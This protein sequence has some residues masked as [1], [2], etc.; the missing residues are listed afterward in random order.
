MIITDQIEENLFKIICL[1]DV[2]AFKVLLESNLSLNHQF[3]GDWMTQSPLISHAEHPSIYNKTIPVVVVIKDAKQIAEAIFDLEG[4][5]AYFSNRAPIYYCCVYR[6]VNVLRI[7]LK[8]GFDPNK[9]QHT[10]PPLLAAVLEG[11]YDCCEALIES[12]KC[13]PYV[14][15]QYGRLY[16]ENRPLCEAARAGRLDIVKLIVEFKQNKKMLVRATITASKNGHEEI[17]LYLLDKLDKGRK[18]SNTQNYPFHVVIAA[19]ENGLHRVIDRMIEMEPRVIQLVDG[20]RTMLSTAAKVNDIELVKRLLSM[21][22]DIHAADKSLYYLYTGKIFIQA[23]SPEAS[24]QFS[25]PPGAQEM[26]ISIPLSHENPSS[27]LAEA[28]ANGNLEIVKLLVS[29]GAD[30]DLSFVHAQRN[31][32]NFYLMCNSSA[33]QL[34]EARGHTK[35]VDFL[36]RTKR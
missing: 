15:D 30:P 27:P 34:A 13:N 32:L 20:N 25:N 2:V 4:T 35:V 21:G 16:R 3:V 7:L 26:L 11:F 24:A 23:G 19:A 22:A 31:D 6:S 29:D 9:K 36:T 18:K 1:D 5:D 8:K 14:K 17:V 33:I 12:G 10:E 28:S